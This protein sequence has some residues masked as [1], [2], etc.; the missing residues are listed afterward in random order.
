MR[1]CNPL[2]GLS[3]ITLA[4]SHAVATLLLKHRLMRVFSTADLAGTGNSAIGS[5]P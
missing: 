4:V 2:V 1:R 3:L 5:K